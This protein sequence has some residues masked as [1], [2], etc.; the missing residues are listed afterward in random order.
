MTT[1]VDFFHRACARSVGASVPLWRI[2]LR[3][4]ES[5]Y[6]GGGSTDPVQ[7]PHGNGAR[8]HRRG[9][10]ESRRILAW[11]LEAYG[12]YRGARLERLGLEHVDLVDDQREFSPLTHPCDQVAYRD[13]TT[14]VG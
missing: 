9:L 14:D 5:P 11:T 1:V 10:R 2:H 3:P 13:P 8:P 12:A 6:W 7:G 4:T